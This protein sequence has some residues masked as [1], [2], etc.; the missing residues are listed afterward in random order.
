M[1]YEALNT[2][3]T[4]IF[5][6]WRQ[7][8]VNY[9][10]FPFREDMWSFPGGLLFEFHD[11]SGIWV[12][13]TS[14]SPNIE[15]GTCLEIWTSPGLCIHLHFGRVP[16]VVWAARGGEKV[17]EERNFGYEIMGIL[18]I[19]GKSWLVKYCHSPICTIGGGFKDFSFLPMGKWF[20]FIFTWVENTN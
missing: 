13:A 10:P 16:E 20:N 11:A 18:L 5:P 9:F 12:V 8:W 6:F 19:L 4:N 7:F 3:K 1:S 15:P 2:L 14:Q 17:G